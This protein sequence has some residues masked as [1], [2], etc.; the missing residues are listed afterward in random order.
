MK[1][2]LPQNDKCSDNTILWWVFTFFWITLSI[3]IFRIFSLNA[4][5]DQGLFLQEIWNCLN[6]RPFESTLAAELSAPVKFD[7]AIPELGYKHLAQHFTPLLIIWSPLVGVMG[8]WALPIIQTGLISLAG[9]ILFLLGKEY[10][11][12]QLSGWIACSFF[13]TG[14]VIGPTLENFHDICLVPLLVFSLLLGISK[15]R[16]LL[17]LIPAILLPL[18]REDVGLLSFSIGLWMIARKP[19]WRIWGF[20]LCL[21]SFMAVSII[22]NILMPLFGSELSER[23]LQERFGQ[24]LNSEVSGTFDVLYAMAKQPYLLLKEIISPLDSTFRFL[25]T[26][27]L[28]LAF[29]PWISIDSIIL[30]IVPLFVALSS[31][32]GNALSVHLRF[33]LYLVPGIFAGTIFWWKENYS[34][35]KQRKFKIFWKACLI[36]SFCFAIAG[37]PHRS[38]SAIIPDSVDPWV[39]IPIHRQVSR[40]FSAQYLL[41]LIPKDESLA[42]ETHLIPLL[43]ERHILMRF[44]ENH[45]FQDLEG[46][47]NSVNYIVSQPRLNLEY[48]KAFKHQSRWARKSIDKIEELTN[49]GRYGVYKCSKKGIILKK[50]F[51]TSTRESVCIKKEIDEIKIIL[52]QIQT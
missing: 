42:A 24:Y 49:S 15:N 46:K 11:S 35:F 12:S 30:I 38:L 51:A 6:G 45:L 33:V 39:H 20:L 23:F 34:L 47:V 25:I 36:I 4:T 37:N 18:V 52:D 17:Y 13:A 7:G 28:P 1:S 9:W 40:G 41:S 2:L 50:G 43:S 5:Y 14:T 21:Y 19:K 3:Q 32:G 10:L 22:T 8:I 48:G 27:G 29:V 26:L 16:F 44:P 31:Q